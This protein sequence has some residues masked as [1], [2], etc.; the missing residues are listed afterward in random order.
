M[1]HSV[2]PQGSFTS[3]PRH[4]AELIE[5]T[6]R[7]LALELAEDLPYKVRGYDPYDNVAHAKDT[8]K[9]DVWQHKPKRT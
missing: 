5:P 9:S 2:R 7:H 3:R 8:L 6:G 4:T 1:K